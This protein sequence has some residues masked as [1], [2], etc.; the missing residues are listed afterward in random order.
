MKNKKLLIILSAS[1]AVLIVTIILI[2]LFS[3]TYNKC[4]KKINKSMNSVVEINEVITVKDGDILVFESLKNFKFKESSATV[5]TTT[6]KLNSS[7][8]L[9]EKVN[10]E[11]VSD[12]NKKDLFKLNLNKDNIK[13]YDLAKN[14]LTITVTKEKVASLFDVESLEILENATLE[15]TFEKNKLIN[16]KCNFKTI[17]NKDVEINVSY[18]Y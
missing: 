18:L 9:E 15:F 2:V 17:S 3:N 6:K 4:V 5:S 16:M 14:K 1:I 11:E 8:T 12:V 10:V 13:E 7:F